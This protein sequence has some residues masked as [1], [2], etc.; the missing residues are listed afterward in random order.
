MTPKRIWGSKS[1]FCRLWNN[2]FETRHVNLCLLFLR[3]GNYVSVR[4]PSPIDREPTCFSVSHGFSA[5]VIYFDR[6]D[7]KTR[8][9]SVYNYFVSLR[10]DKFATKP[11]KNSSDVY[12]NIQLFITCDQIYH[13]ALEHWNSLY[14]KMDFHILSGAIITSFKRRFLCLRRIARHEAKQKQRK[15]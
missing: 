3:I 5:W 10:Y 8:G 15:M 12:R 2:L 11:N 1:M 4:R 13:F 7:W 14:L 6:R 9:L